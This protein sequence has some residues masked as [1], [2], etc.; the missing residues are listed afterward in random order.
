MIDVS[1]RMSQF[2][3]RL[4]NRVDSGDEGQLKLESVATEQE[5]VVKDDIFF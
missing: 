5:E 3:H 4:I 2:L 1:L